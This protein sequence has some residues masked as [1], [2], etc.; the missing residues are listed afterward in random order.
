MGQS[1]ILF[2]KAAIIQYHRPGGLDIRNLVSHHPAIWESK[3]KV[4]A[5]LSV[6]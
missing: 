2:A 1:V 5:R 4:P 6:F 3:I